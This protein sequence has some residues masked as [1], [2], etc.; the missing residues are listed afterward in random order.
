MCVSYVLLFLY[1][2][3]SE[4]S[5]YHPVQQGYTFL[6]G[7]KTNSHLWG[8]AIIFCRILSRVCPLG[9]GP[10]FSKLENLNQMAQFYDIT[11]LSLQDFGNKHFMSPQNS[12]TSKNLLV[13]YLMLHLKHVYYCSMTSK[14]YDMPII[15]SSV[16]MYL[17]RTSHLLYLWNSLYIREHHIQLGLIYFSLEFKDM[18]K[19]CSQCH[20]N[21]DSAYSMCFIVF[22]IHTWINTS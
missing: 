13:H 16:C 10:H 7:V 15:Y 6:E 14:S 20:Q 22:L 9:F 2:I 19:T 3:S 5:I 17:W 12:G 8:V 4:F 11:L 21:Q 1:I 18:I